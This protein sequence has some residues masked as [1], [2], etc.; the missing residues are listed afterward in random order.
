MASAKSKLQI[1]S[2]FMATIRTGATGVSANVEIW[3]RV[4]RICH[5]VSEDEFFTPSKEHYIEMRQNLA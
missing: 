3:Q 4:R 1:A 5:T 2:S